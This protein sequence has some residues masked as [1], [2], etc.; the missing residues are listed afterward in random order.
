MRTLSL[1]ADGTLYADVWNYQPNLDANVDMNWSLHAWDA[2][3]L[4][5]GARTA[6]ARHSE[7]R[8]PLDRDLP[9]DP[10]SSQ[11]AP[12][13][14]ALTARRYDDIGNGQR[15][16]RW[17]NLGNYQAPGS[18]PAFG[19][20]FVR[21]PAI[22]LS[23]QEPE[24]SVTAG[25]EGGGG[26]FVGA[27]DRLSGGYLGRADQR[28]FKYHT[29]DLQ[30]DQM[31]H[32]NL[33]DFAA[34]SG[35]FVVSGGL[36]SKILPSSAARPA[37]RRGTNLAH[38][39][40]SEI[41]GATLL[42]AWGKS[43]LTPARDSMTVAQA[44][45]W[46]Q[47]QIARIPDLVANAPNAEA[48]MARAYQLLVDMRQ[49]AKATLYDP[50][51]A[52]M[53]E[54]RYPLPSLDRLIAKYRGTGTDKLSGSALYKQVVADIGNL[55]LPRFPE[56]VGGCFIAG[57][58]V[59]TDQGLKPI[60]AIRI[61]DRVLSQP[62]A[63]GEKTYKRVVD[64]FAF[65]EKEV[66]VVK[67]RNWDPNIGDRNARV[68]H[69]Y[70][71]GNHPFW[72]E[73]LGWTAAENLC[74]GNQLR[75]ADGSEASV[76]IVWPVI[77][78]PLPGVGWVSAD[79][80]GRWDPAHESD[81]LERAHIVDFRNG[82]NLWQYP[83]W[84]REEAGVPYREQFCFD[85]IDGLFGSEAM[86]D[87]FYGEDRAYKT[88]VYNLEVEDF[89]TYYVGEL[90]V[91][92]HNR[93]CLGLELLN[94]AKGHKVPDSTPIVESKNLLHEQIKRFVKDNDGRYPTGL[95]VLPSDTNA[96]MVSAAE[97]RVTPRKILPWPPF[98]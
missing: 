4:I 30:Y 81:G 19:K 90:G 33:I 66:F 43:I 32:G 71:T 89:H 13:I 42:G 20:T 79:T 47:A 22:V 25:L 98:I 24:V 44:G 40:P 11:P 14:P 70:C 2:P 80:L 54:A 21:P 78:T 64:T 91:W 85:D 27:L 96:W 34:T 67:I 51:L 16:D 29:G 61:G 10:H 86:A 15:F 8:T 1:G 74:D 77:R 49:G 83:M 87:I 93:D 39:S 17:I 6:Y 75:L 58:L 3:S 26:V 48:A 60:E 76:I 23:P 68:R 92:V 65:E 94:P 45:N 9:P 82:C 55:K 52:A 41:S 46:F 72:V 7:R 57:T 50:E 95:V 53:L 56:Q 84:R 97:R 28:M 12:Q 69:L 18:T 63:G 36:A 37:S 38:A 62:E 31:V 5:Q 88:R 35:A 73:E 59:H